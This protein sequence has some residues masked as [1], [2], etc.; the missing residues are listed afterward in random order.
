MYQVVHTGSRSTRLS[1]LSY[2][3]FPLPRS[4]PRI[5]LF[6]TIFLVSFPAF[7]QHSSHRGQVIEAEAEALP[8]PRMKIERR[9]SSWEGWSIF[10]KRADSR[11]DVCLRW[12]HQSV[13]VNDTVYIYGG[14]AKTSAG[15]TTNTW[16][17]LFLALSINM[18]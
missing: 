12:S 7:F 4:L 11:T 1:F 18:G 14:Q 6:L 5:S 15:Q 16:S 10:E 2:F 8:E 3:Y 17:T 13:L 9:E